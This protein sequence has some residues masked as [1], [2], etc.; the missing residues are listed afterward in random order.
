VNRKKEVGGNENLEKGSENDK[1][2]HL[3]NIFTHI[4][5]KYNNFSHIFT[6]STNSPSTHPVFTHPEGV[7]GGVERKYLF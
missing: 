3:Q 4:Q 5:N 2:T 6:T 1:L 7:F